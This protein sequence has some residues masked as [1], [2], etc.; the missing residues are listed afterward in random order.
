M[1]SLDALKLSLGVT[2]D[3]RFDLVSHLFAISSFKLFPASFSFSLHPLDF[4]A[5]LLFGYHDFS[6]SLIFFSLCIH[7]NLFAS[8]LALI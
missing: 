3:M 6:V 1:V 4:S 8:L 7:L 2:F 5:S